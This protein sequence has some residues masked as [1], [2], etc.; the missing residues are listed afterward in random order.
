MNFFEGFDFNMEK[1]KIKA[2]FYHF[3]DNV[4]LSLILFS[5]C[6]LYIFLTEKNKKIRDLFG[7]YVISIIIIVWNPLVIHIL[8]NFINFSSMYRLYY[9]I[10]MYPVIAYCFTKVIQ[11]LS[12]KSKKIL[13]TV[14]IF[15]VVLIFGKSIYSEGGLREV[16][17]FYK[18]PDESVFVAEAIYKD[19]KYKEKRAIVPYGMSSHIQQIHST[20][21]LA[22]TRIVKSYSLENGL[23]STADTDDP[24]GNELVEKFSEGDTKYIVDYCN[25]QRINYIVYDDNS[26]LE[27]P[28]ENYGFEKIDSAYNFSVYRRI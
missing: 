2:L 27:E 7:W 28:F 16:N 10:P 24:A 3:F 12:K 22:Y 21:Q 20:I 25:S 17:N 23:P 18:L 15:S 11:G 8:E 6:V 5:L 1:E 4:L 9:M 19:E 26:Y 13:C 14:I